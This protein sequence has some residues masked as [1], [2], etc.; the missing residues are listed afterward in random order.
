L[1]KTQSQDYKRVTKEG[2]SPQVDVKYKAWRDP[3]TATF[4]GK[5]LKVV[6]PIRYAA[7]IRAKVKNPLG[8]DWIT[9][10]EDETWGTAAH[11]QRMKVTIELALGIDDNWKVTSV[12]KLD[13]ISHSKAPSGNF[14]AK[15]GINVCTSKENLAPTVQSHLNDYLVPKIQDGLK[16]ADAEVAKAFDLQKRA[17]SVWAALQAPQQIQKANDK[18]CPT[19]LGAACKQEAWLLFTPAGLGMTQLMLEGD[20]LGVD[21]SLEGKIVTVLGKKPSVKTKALP[22]LEK[23]VGPTEFQLRTSL[24][25]PLSTLSADAQKALGGASFSVGSSKLELENVGLAIGS[26]KVVTLSIT[27]KGAHAGK[28]VAKAK[29]TYDAK[30]ALLEL[31][32]LEFDAATEALFKNELKGLDEAALKKKLAAALTIDLS[33]GSVALQRAVTAGLNKA[34]PGKLTVKGTLSDVSIVDLAVADGAVDLHVE[35]VGS[36]AIEYVP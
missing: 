18:T 3:I 7:N 33:S 23:P 12:S 4:S 31:S 36:L 25:L 13:G 28:L 34:L 21:L 30:K 9:V 8:S 14:C 26:D 15:V 32:S 2:Q 22:K 16:K 6:V 29:L 35:L 1:P 19:L 11:P 17:Q 27:T 10:A 5:T 20:D 24:E